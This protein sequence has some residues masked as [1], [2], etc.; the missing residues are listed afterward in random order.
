MGFLQALIE[1]SPACV[2][3]TDS[4]HWDMP[5]SNF[6]TLGAKK[7]MIFT[8]VAYTGVYNFR[9]FAPDWFLPDHCICVI[10][11]NSTLEV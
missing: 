11:D 10:D 4:F 1:Y 3:D 7:N 2:R 8:V 9:L 5:L 6:Y